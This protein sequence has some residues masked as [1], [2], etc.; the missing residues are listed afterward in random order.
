MTLKQISLALL[1][2]ITVDMYPRCAASQVAYRK[3]VQKQWRLSGWTSL[4]VGTTLGD[5]ANDIKKAMRSAGLGHRS[6]DQINWFGTIV[7]TKGKNHPF[8]TSGWN[9]Y[10]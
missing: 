4:S 10:H 1:I 7:E 9:R 2:I 8:S 5:L 3:T 6:P